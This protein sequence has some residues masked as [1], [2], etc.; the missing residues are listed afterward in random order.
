MEGL[1]NLLR[2]K[3]QESALCGFDQPPSGVQT[4]SL[5]ARPSKDKLSIAFKYIFLLD[6]VKVASHSL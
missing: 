1:Q 5:T 4:L 6:K 2:I 3:L